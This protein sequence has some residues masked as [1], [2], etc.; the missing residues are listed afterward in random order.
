MRI[1]NANNDTR[2]GRKRSMDTQTYIKEVPVS[3]AVDD[4]V[5]GGG[6]AGLA[7]AIS[8]ART[9]ATTMLIETNG[10]L[11]GNLTA[12]LVGPCMTSYSLDGSIQLIKGVFED[13]VNRMVD[14]GAAIHPSNTRAGD[15]YSGF[16]VYGHDKVTPFEPEAAKIV[17]NRMCTEAGVILRF[18]SSVVDVSVEDGRATGVVIADKEGLHVQ[19]AARIVDCSADGDVVAFAGGA[20][21]YGRPSD[22]MVQPMTLFFRVTDVDD[23]AVQEYVSQHPDEI[24]PFASLIEHAREE[25]TFKLPRRGVGL[26]RTMRK[27]VWRIN[28]SRVLGKNGTKAS[29]LSAAEI[30]GREQVMMLMDFFRS[31][32]PGFANAQLLDTAATIGVRETRRI[33]GEY[34]LTVEDLQG[35]T[36]FD[37]V[38]ALCGYPV[39]IHDPAG[40]GGGASDHYSTANGYE[41]PFRALVPRDLDNVVVAGRCVSATHEA[42]G[43]IRV[44]PPSFAMGQAAGTAAALSVVEN[45]RLRDIDVPSL[46]RQLLQDNAYLGERHLAAV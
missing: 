44:M 37:D 18:H 5:V 12:G 15:A 17:A 13:F 7:A 42:L 39:D 46:Q 41:I 24:R 22:S 32:L 30:E 34:V 38:I 27:G 33:V 45:V 8:S 29:D 10:Y 9:G 28:T 16:I 31:E 2:K 4:V 26:Y 36:E 11:G 20:T 1:T 21:E 6:P 35:P 19:P 3:S 23:D 40:T 25:G 43:A 14:M